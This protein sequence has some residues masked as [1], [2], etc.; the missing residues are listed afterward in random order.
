MFGGLNND[1]VLWS[2]FGALGLTVLILILWGWRVISG[3]SD[4]EKASS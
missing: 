1:F 4:S 2:V 3:G